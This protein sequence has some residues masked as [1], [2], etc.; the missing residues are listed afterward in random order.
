MVIFLILA[1]LTFVVMYGCSIIVN[2]LFHYWWVN[3]VMFVVVVLFFIIRSSGVG[4]GWLMPL[5]VGSI[6]V[7]LASWTTR[8][9]RDEGY[10][11]FQERRRS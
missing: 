10:N 2:M 7:A 9:L 5:I 1:L 8:V 3:L 11:L 4:S 6:G